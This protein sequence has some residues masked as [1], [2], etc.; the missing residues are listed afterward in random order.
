MF[1]DAVQGDALR[2][3]KAPGTA[4]D[5][6]RLGKDPQPATMA[7]FIETTEDNGGVHLNSGIPNHAFYLAATALGGFAWKHAGLIWYDTILNSKLSPDCGFA[8]FAAATTTAATGRFG[9][10]SREVQAVR[11]AW[12]SVGVAL[13]GETGG[14]RR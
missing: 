3:L 2:S 6:P 12:Q 9:P 10:E 5:D 1:T 13:D 8:A 4:Y 11:Q 14:E 7:D